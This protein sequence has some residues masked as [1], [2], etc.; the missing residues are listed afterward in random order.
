MTTGGAQQSAFSRDFRFSRNEKIGR[1]GP[2]EICH[3]FLA[4]ETP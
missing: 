2:D 3:Y 1:V 4:S